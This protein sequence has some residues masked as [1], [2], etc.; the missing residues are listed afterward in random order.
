MAKLL[1]SLDIDESKYLKY[2]M[3]GNLHEFEESL[4]E[5]VMSHIYDKLDSHFIEKVLKS[6]A[7]VHKM[8]ALASSQRMGKLQIR[9]TSL[10]LRTGSYIEV[11]THYACKVPKQ[12]ESG[13]HLAFQ[14]W[15][16]IK[17]ASPSYYSQVS[18][19][20]VLCNSFGIVESVFEGLQIK[21]NLERLRSLSLAVS[22]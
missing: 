21:C 11:E 15:G 8:P 13:R 22:K 10:Q 7:F 6:K 16:I 20:Y 17:G 14:Y 3:E 19:F 4:Y 12:T 5:F 1:Q 9:K 18:K 2:L